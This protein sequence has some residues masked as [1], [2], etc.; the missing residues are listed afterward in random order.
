MPRQH[1]KCH[2]LACLPPQCQFDHRTIVYKGAIA[3]RSS[4]PL[5]EPLVVGA[6]F[7]PP[8][9]PVCYSRPHSYP[10]I[11][12]IEVA[13]AVILILN[14]CAQDQLAQPLVIDLRRNTGRKIA[15]NARNARVLDG[16]ITRES[17]GGELRREERYRAI[18]A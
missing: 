2:P 17:N 15:A 10:Y 14:R 8:V 12:P 13:V 9:K 6:E 11:T 5:V 4:R 7:N 16:A 18:E 3:L 1:Q